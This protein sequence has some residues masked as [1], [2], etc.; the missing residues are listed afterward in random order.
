MINHEIRNAFGWTFFLV[1]ALVCSMHA[2]RSTGNSM[3]GSEIVPTKFGEAIDRDV[4]AVR[5]ATEPFKVLD[6]AV[7]AGYERQ[8]AQCVENPPQGGMGF[9]HK[10]SALRDAKLEIDKPEILLYA[11]TPD[12]QYKL[13]GVEYI[14][15]ISAWSRTEPPTILGQSL[16]RSDTL[17]VW[18]LHV[19]IWEPNPSGL[20]ADWNPRVKCLTNNP[21]FP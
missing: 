10:N 8:V 7:G 3:F 21:Q 16:R 2:Q 5:A 6:N 9:H 20:F 15:P 19:W 4:M 11:R 12:G 18:Y 17:G 13:V 1:A 14:V